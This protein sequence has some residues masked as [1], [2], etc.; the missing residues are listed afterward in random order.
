MEFTAKM[1]ADVLQGEV[2]GNPQTAVSGISKIEEGKPGTLCFL[3]NPKYEKYLYS[4][5]ASIVLVS[6][7]LLLT[8]P[9]SATL[10]RVDDP[11]QSLA[12]LLELYESA[13]PRETGIDRQVSIA[14]SAQIGENPYIGA[15][16]YIG[17]N[18]R[19]GNNVRIFPQV[20][21]GDGV[22][23]GNDS[24]L[25]AGVKVYAG[26]RIGNGC[27]IHAGAVI[28]A[29]GFGFAPHNGVYKKIPQ[30]GNVVIEDQ[31][32]IGANTCIDRA[33]M[34]STRIRKGTK[35]D[36]LIQIAHNVEVGEH[37]VIASQTGISG[38][39]RIGSHCM[40]GG[41]VGV[42][43]HAVVGDNVKVGAQSGIM[44]NV[45]SGEDIMGS[46]AFKLRDYLRA[47]ALFRHL[48]D[49]RTRLDAI[50]KQIKKLL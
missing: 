36:N 19:I 39:T 37:T 25:Y 11:Y 48:P 32:E 26:C 12:V 16:A 23:I 24:T 29:D 50:E 13:K 45:Q 21:L 22:E 4:T 47:A 27:I 31:V 49:F 35:L 46:P 33:T 41:Q 10:I 6:K 30:I 34:G 2:E 40:F 1:I 44:G 38:S 7:R 8:A 42:A 14:E 43:G 20:F 3:S 17:K 28:G 9:V 15:F 18:V 5:G